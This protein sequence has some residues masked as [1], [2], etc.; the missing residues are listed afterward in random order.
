MRCVG[1]LAS[2]VAS[3]VLS[4][5]SVAQAGDWTQPLQ[6]DGAVSH[7]GAAAIGD[8]IYLAGGASITGPRQ[9]FDALDVAGQR[10]RALTSLP[11]GVQQFGFA[12]LNGTL[13]L[14]GGLAGEDGKP[15]RHVWAFKDG[16]WSERARLPKDRYGH[17]AVAVGDKIYVF[18]GVGPE[19]GQVSVYDSVGDRWSKVGAM[20]GVRAFLAGATDG[21]KIYLVGGQAGGK[22]SGR[23]DIF[24]PATGAWTQGAALP[25]PRAGLTAAFIN[26][27]LHV[28]G[29][30][31]PDAMKTYANHDSYAPGANAWT[32]GSPMPTARHSLAS[33]VAGGKWYVIGGGVGAGFFTVFTAT[34]V[35]E[36]YT[37]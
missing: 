21:T 9:D 34:D 37:P 16:N 1:L 35:I 31:S 3:A 11:E 30:V 23:L 15:T 14:I 18:G 10:L 32:K 4:L 33:A 25:T 19:A 7:L 12:A 26:G 22:A 20:P 27:E 6:L 13:Y 5:A 2:L 36:A 29:G 8:E 17:V 28:A 24:T